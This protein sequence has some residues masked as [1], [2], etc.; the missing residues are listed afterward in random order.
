MIFALYTITKERMDGTIILRK[1][2]LGSL[3]KR[4]R[5]V[6]NHNQIR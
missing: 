6:N 2:T 3:V 1:V 4:E 5:Y